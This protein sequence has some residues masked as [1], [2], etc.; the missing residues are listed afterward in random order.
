MIPG[1]QERWRLRALRDT[2]ENVHDIFR[3]HSPSMNQPNGHQLWAQGKSMW[4]VHVMGWM[5]HSNKKAIIEARTH[6]RHSTDSGRQNPGYVLC[7][8]TCRKFSNVWL[9]VYTAVISRLGII[10]GD[11]LFMT[12]AHWDLECSACFWGIYH[13]LEVYVEGSWMGAQRFEPLQWKCCIS[14]KKKNRKK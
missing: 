5:V 9:R 7:E 13:M 6:H 11:W 8:S 12:R 3:Y 1:T 2:C 4:Y 14:I 10:D